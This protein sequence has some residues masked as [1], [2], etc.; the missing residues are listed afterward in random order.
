MKREWFLKAMLVLHISYSMILF[1]LVTGKPF[2]ILTGIMGMILSLIVA[3]I[4]V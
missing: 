1:G 4:W 2:F 3:A